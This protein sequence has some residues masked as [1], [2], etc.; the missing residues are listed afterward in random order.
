MIDKHESITAKICS[1]VRAY[2]SIY[3]HEKIFDDSLAYDLLSQHEYLKVGQLIEHNF[4]VNKYDDDFGFNRALIDDTVNRFLS[5][6]LLSRI[7]YTEDS[8]YE[9]AKKGPVQYVL[10]GAG[11]DTFAFRNTNL[12]IEIYELDHPDTGYYKKEK[13]KSLEWVIPENVH[14]VP[15]DFNTQS[16]EEVLSNS[17]FDPNKRTF[18]SILG[19]TYYLSLEVF[20]KTIENLSSITKNESVIVFDY[21]DDTTFTSDENSDVTKLHQ[22]TALLGEKMAHGYKFLEIEECFKNYKGMVL[23][24]LAPVDI[25]KKYFQNRHD[26]MQAYA[27]VHLVKGIIEK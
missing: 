6:I 15:I 11:L 2:H 23:E 17:S 7:R 25:N 16:I 19:V 8:L 4:D 10:L 18:F 22:M 21:P 5:P 20:S 24:H 12:N 3:S 27:N 14:F 1:F 26:G 13:I 9:Y